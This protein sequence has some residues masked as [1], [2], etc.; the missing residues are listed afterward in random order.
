MAGQAHIGDAQACGAGGTRR[1][2]HSAESGVLPPRFCAQAF[3]ALVSR[4]RAAT[5]L[6]RVLNARIPIIK[7]QDAATGAEHAA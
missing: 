3:S 6:Q 4:K 2:L 5:V 7:I 1:T